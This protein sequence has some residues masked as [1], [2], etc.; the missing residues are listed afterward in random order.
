MKIRLSELIILLL[1]LPAICQAQDLNTM[2]LM[3]VAGRNIE[4]GE[5]IRMYRKNLDPGKNLPV[6]DYINQYALF[7]MKVAD[8]I[9]E[10]F[11][12]TT[13]FRNELQGYR[14][15]LS[16]NYLTD[17]HTRDELLKKAYQRSLKEINT[18][19]ILVALPQDAAPADTLK[20]WKKANEIRVRIRNG[21]SFEMVAR[22]T[23]DD[24][25]VRSNGGNLGYITVF[26]LIMPL[27]DAVYSLR[28]GA[29]SMPVRSPYGYHILKVTDIR[30][31]KGRILVAHIMKNAPP[32]ASE[33]AV[34]NAEEQ[35]NAIYRQ[36]Q[37]GASFSETAKRLSDHKESALKGGVL[38]WF[39]T[40][41]MIPSFSEAA[42]SIPDTGMYTK[43]VR[44]IYGWHIIK[45]LDR[46]PP[47]TFAETSS[48]LESRINQSYLDSLSRKSFVDKLRK[49]YGFRINENS[50]DWFNQ[51]TDSLI[52]A[53]QKKY[54]PSAIPEGNLYS[55]AGGSLKNSEFAAYVGKY[56]SII[57]SQDPSLFIRTLIDNSS[58]DQ[59]FA[60]ENSA[61]EKKY[62]EFRYLMNEF[63]D[64]ILLFDIS[65]RK[66]WDRISNDSIGLH[67]YYE[68]HKYDSLSAKRLNAKIY[69]L[70]IPGGRNQLVSAYKKYSGKPDADSRL[71]DK[72]NKNSDTLLLIEEGTWKSGEDPDIDQAERVSGPAFFI[73]KNYPSLIVVKSVEDPLPLKFGE[74]EEKMMTGFQA[75]LESEWERQLKNKYAVL[76]DSTVLSKVRKELNDE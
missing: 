30:P 24:Q 25:S 46:K 68:D 75:F 48:Y 65:N 20:A 36:L 6:G 17:T 23:S 15:Q 11:D 10:G 26:Q 60:Y 14:N 43:P 61:L 38:D 69:T 19:H 13:S 41:E 53:G 71:L 5:F 33:E 72:F 4:A 59:I 67:K 3:T 49:E 27:E 64:G 51:N 22:S 39:G 2:S 62:P 74:V 35:I 54:D 29:L 28:K 57:A 9:S 1:A 7:K 56:G 76:I 21:E 34:K 50:V 45:L 66:V 16:G 52:M 12:T 58:S 47:G 70:Q 8:A 42:F 18:W 37:E 40:G 63:H 44:T 31:A 32:G 73:R 55:F